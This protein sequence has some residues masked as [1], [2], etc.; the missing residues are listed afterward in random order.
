MTIPRTPELQ[1]L[2][3]NLHQNGASPMI[4]GGAVRDWVIGL[5]PKDLDIEVFSLNPQT[6][7]GILARHGE[8]DHVGKSFGVYKLRLG[9]LTYDISLPRKDSKIA[10]MQ[11]HKSIAPEFDQ[12]LTPLEASMRRDFTINSLFYDPIKEKL[13][14]PHGGIDDIKRKLLKHTSI[15][16]VED[17][18]R[19]LRAVQF[20]ARFGFSMHEST[21]N[22]CKEIYQRGELK[23]LSQERVREELNKFLL[24]GKHH[25]KAI[26]V[27]NQTMWMEEFKELKAIANL[28]QDPQWHPE[29]NVLKHTFHA[30]EALQGIKNFRDLEEKEQLVYCLG[31][32]CHDLGKPATTYREYREELGREV[33]TSPNHPQEGLK[34]TESLLKRFGYGPSI[35]KRAKLLT[36]Y[37]M[38]HLWVKDAKGVK[39]LAAKLSPSNPHSE[40]AKIEETIQG[41]SI[42]IEAD[43]SGRPPLTKGL[44]QKMKNIL[45]IAD[46]EGCLNGPVTP[47]LKGADIIALGIAPGKELGSILKQ[48]YKKQLESLETSYQELKNWAAKNLR[49]LV[50]DAGGPPPLIT[51]ED[52]KNAMLTPSKEF[53][54]ILNKSYKKQLS[55]EIKTKEEAQKWLAGYLQNKNQQINLL[56]L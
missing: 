46:R 49:K 45:E 2:L 30:L 6:L 37:H 32:L 31:V 26:D 36:L 15:A 27:L 7:E 1:N 5:T 51:G 14:D 24:K 56:A 8:V 39:T 47:H 40:N 54:D 10:G 33:V 23:S 3:I 34:P 52:L 35:I 42:V 29:G 12:A 25:T 44:P 18:L 22:L 55:G 43:H 50:I 21:A 48:A 28:E 38:D 53:S 17:P 9:G 16:F 19:S 4:V 20:S 13:I 41:L 11:G